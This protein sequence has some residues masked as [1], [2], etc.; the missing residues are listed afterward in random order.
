MTLQRGMVAGDNP[1]QTALNIIGRINP[2]TGKRQGGVIGLTVAQEGWV[3][4]TKRY[5]EQGDSKY[6]SL[7]LRDKR[8]DSVVKKAIADNKPLPK[9]QIDRLVTSYKT[10]ALRYRGE[11]IARTETLQA[12]NK[13]AA[14]S[15]AQAI[16]E[17]TLTRS[18][19]TKEWDDVGG[20]RVR[21]THRTMGKKYG[22]GKGIGVDDVFVSPSGSR[23]KHPGDTSLNA[24]AS[25]IVNCRCKADY[26]V[27]WFQGIENG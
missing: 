12:L 21:H 27:D 3:A 15:Y 23:L 11:T 6:F 22:K 1:R 5:L 2:T 25:E 24:D 26:Q 8:F 9:A 16:N 13:G 7:K 19:I 4:N 10:K 18:Q 14:A 17:G 20:P